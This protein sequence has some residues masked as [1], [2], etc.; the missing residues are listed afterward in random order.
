MFIAVIIQSH[1]AWC[2]TISRTAFERV[3]R[4]QNDAKV[5]ERMLLVLNVVYYNKIAAHVVR[6]IHRSKGWASQ[7]L[8]RYREDGIEGL[9]DKPKGGRH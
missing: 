1:F 7:W 4:T 2:L 8:K 6:D 3:Y 9:K 5:K